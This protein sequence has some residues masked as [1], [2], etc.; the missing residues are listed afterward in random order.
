MPIDVTDPNPGPLGSACELA[1]LW[2][3]LVHSDY[4]ELSMEISLW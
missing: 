3:H 2:G 1:Y 4:F